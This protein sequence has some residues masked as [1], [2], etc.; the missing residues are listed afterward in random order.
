MP[1]APA[2]CGTSGSI[3]ARHRS[4]D[5]RRPRRAGLGMRPRPRRIA[6]PVG[7]AGMR[8]VNCA[9]PVSGLR[10]AG[11][12]VS[13]AIASAM[14]PS[15]M[16]RVRARRAEGA[17]LKDDVG[18][19]RDAEHREHRARLRDD[20]RDRPR[21]AANPPAASSGWRRRRRRT[22]RVGVAGPSANEDGR[23]AEPV[24]EHLRE[25]RFVPCPLDC[26]PACTS[27]RPSAWTW[28]ARARGRADRRLDIARDADAE[29]LAAPA[30]GALARLHAPSRRAA[31]RVRG[32][33][34]KSP[35]S[36]VEAH[37]SAIRTAA[38]G[39]RRCGGGSR[40]GRCADARPPGRSRRSM[41]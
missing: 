18:L 19:V 39:V 40:D 21:P 24:G 8:P 4:T 23:N 30:R 28:R 16:R 38:R 9:S 41:R 32:C 1:P 6:P 17:V 37:R 20:L 12:V 10:N 29:S 25:R 14:S 35:E 31:R 13:L 33:R 22:R 3:G 34:R 2:P 27:T 36:W 26:V 15:V 5:T 11:G 7:C